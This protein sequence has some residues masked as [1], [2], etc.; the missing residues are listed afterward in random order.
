[1]PIARVSNIKFDGAIP[2]WV[3]KI[4]RGL[5]KCLKTKLSSVRNAAKNSYLPQ[6]NRN[7]TLKRASRM[8]LSVARSA[9]THVKMQADLPVNSIRQP[10]HVAEERQ[11]FPSSRQKAEMFSAANALHK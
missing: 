3:I 1:M 5:K 9:V 11:R 6:A 7:S 4:K 8:S 2:S 10:A